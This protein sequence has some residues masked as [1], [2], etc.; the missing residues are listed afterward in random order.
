[1]AVDKV[2][3]DGSIT[4]EES[5]SMDT[6]IDV[7]EGFRF[8]AGFC[9]SAFVNDERRNVMH[10]EEPLVMVTDYKITQVEQILPILELVAREAR[11]L[12][13]V[14]EDIEA[15]LGSHDHE[16]HAWFS[17][18]CRHQG[19]IPAKSDAIF[20]LTLQSRRVQ[21]SSPESQDKLQTAT[22]DQ[23]GTAKSVEST[24]VG[25]ILVGGNC[26]YEAV[27]TRI[28]SLKAE[29][30]TTDDFAECER[31]QG[32]IVRL[33]SGVAVIHVGGATQVEMT[34]RKHRIEDALEAVRSAQEEGV[35][36]GGGTALLRASNTLAVTTDHDEQAIG[37]SIV[38]KACEAPFRQ[39]CRNG[40]K[41]E[42]LLLAHVVD[43][44]NDMGYDF[45]N[46]T[47]TNLYERGILDPVR[48]TKSALK[49]AASCAGTLITT[50][51]GIIQVS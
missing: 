12:V 16:R 9:A 38:K 35:I 49:N 13:I 33:S 50:N 48:V 4:I 44:P 39:M 45:R 5:R 30:T 31:I 19:S 18:D 34:E 41:S 20:Y 47:L 2:G 1:M 32:R 11:P 40:G 23:L 7:T 10:Y 43:Q 27:E 46:G 36:G 22:L 3:Q 24:K 29:I 6:S 8:P 17:K 14:A 21:H 42:D 25:T 26:D 37:I 51:Y 28:E 15:S